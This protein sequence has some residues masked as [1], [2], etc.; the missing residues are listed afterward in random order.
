MKFVT[1][2]FFG[3]QRLHN[4]IMLGGNRGCSGVMYKGFPYTYYIGR[5]A[6]KYHITSVIS[7]MK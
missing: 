4:E 3:N 2:L 6:G 5:S 7:H 1:I